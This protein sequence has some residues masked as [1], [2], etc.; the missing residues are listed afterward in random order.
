M[1][2]CMATGAQTQIAYVKED[3][4]GVT[5][6]SPTLQEVGRR[7]GGAPV[8][9]KPLLSSQ[10]IRSD[11]QMAPAR[12]GNKNVNVPLTL[13]SRFGEQDEFF[14]ALLGDTFTTTTEN[15]VGVDFDVSGTITRSVGDWSTNFSVNDAIKIAGSTSNNGV[16]TITD[17]TATVLTVSEAVVTEAT[18]T[19]DVQS[20]QLQNGT[21]VTSFT[22][23]EYYADLNDTDKYLAWVGARPNTLAL[24]S[25]IDD[26][27][28]MTWEFIGKD[29]GIPSDVSL[30]TVNGQ[31]D[32]ESMIHYD[33]AIYL[34]N[35]AIANI[36]ALTLNV[37]NKIA[38]EYVLGTAVVVCI[39]F[40][41]AGCVRPVYP[42]YRRH[43]PSRLQKT[44]ALWELDCA[45]L[46]FCAV[47][48]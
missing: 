19:I 47:S 12:T 1:A 37:N 22:F 8:L 16:F 26:H 32:N 20:I 2:N 24:S 23:Q 35:T 3:T 9:E 31:T 5:P 29:G 40:C 36:T 13:E 11:R 30:G 10:M 46:D 44:P 7:S 27:I 48:R 33:G 21:D 15:S 25:T 34:D 14:E 6:N 43:I 4:W 18:A 39:H 41:H 38:N 42:G 17:L 45:I 28:T